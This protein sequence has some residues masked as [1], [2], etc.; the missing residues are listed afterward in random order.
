MMSLCNHNILCHSTMGWWGAY[1]NKNK[2]KKVLYPENVLKLLHA[3]LHSNP[4]CL[5]RTEQY[6]MK[7]WVSVN[8]ES[9]FN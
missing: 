8:G 9:I 3:T 6:F 5:E 7:D 2:D 1:L 4:V